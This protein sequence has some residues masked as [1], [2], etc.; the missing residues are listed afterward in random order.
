MSDEVPNFALF[1]LHPLSRKTRSILEY[2]QSLGHTPPDIDHFV[3]TARQVAREREGML[4][5]GRELDNDIW[6][7]EGNNRYVRSTL[8]V[9]AHAHKAMSRKEKRVSM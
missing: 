2:N 8:R 7:K 3:V 4:T 9:G 1:T 5:V 6:Y